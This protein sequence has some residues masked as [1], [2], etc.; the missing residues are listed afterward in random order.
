[1]NR[2]LMTVLFISVGFKSTELLAVEVD[3]S[4]STYTCTF[5]DST[6]QRVVHIDKAD[7]KVVP[8][9]DGVH[10][11]HFAW[12]DWTLNLNIKKTG[13]VREIVG[14][15][16]HLHF[17]LRS[18]V[19]RVSVNCN[20]DSVLDTLIIGRGNSQASPNARCDYSQTEQ[21]VDS[22]KALAQERALIICSSDEVEQMSAWRTD[23]SCERAGENT[24]VLKVRAEATFACRF[25]N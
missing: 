7:H 6:G 18:H 17:K 4:E 3:P 1:M 25:S 10:E 14:A 19:P 9:D 13:E 22:A 20:N 5:F 8:L 11:L 16:S 21:L 2:L 15:A 23:V 12:F 24:E